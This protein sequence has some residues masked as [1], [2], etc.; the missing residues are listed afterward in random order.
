MSDTWTTTALAVLLII[1]AL[2][3]R[4]YSGRFDRER[5]RKQVESRGGKVLDISW[6]P[7]AGGWW[8]PRNVRHYEVT[9]RTHHGGVI[10]AVCATSGSTIYWRDVPPGFED[11][12][13]RTRA[14]SAGNLSP[15]DLAQS[16]ATPAETIVCLRCG[17]KIPA[18]AT[19]C[20]KCGWSYQSG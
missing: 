12:D 9:Y 17:A 4:L 13:H 11:H 6:N 7:F 16:S 15:E 5:I 18:R 8:G 20:S 3:A 19:H 10:S 2:V 14:A 1:L